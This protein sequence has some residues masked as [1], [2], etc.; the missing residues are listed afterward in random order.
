SMT[1]Q[2]PDAV[3]LG[4][5]CL[6][7][8]PG[9]PAGSTAGE[10]LFV[11]G[12]LI[13]VTDAVLSSGGATSN[14]GLALH[15]LGFD[16]RIVGKIGDDTFGRALLG[17]FQAEAEHLARDMII[18]PD[19]GTS[20]SIIL[21]PPGRDRMI[22]HS[23]GP[24]ATFASADVPDETLRG[25]LV[26]FGY[27]PLMKKIY[28]NDGAELEHLFRRAKTNGA[29]TSLDMARPDPDS[30]AGRLD[31][32]AFF[33]RVLPTVDVF[34]PSIDELVFMI[35]RALFDQLER[36]ANGGNPAA[37]LSMDEINAIADDILA[38]GPAMVGFKLGDEGFY[39]K[40]TDDRARLAAMGSLTPPDLDAWRGARL[41]SPCRC[42]EVA[43]TIGSGD[44]TIAGFL[45]GLF[46]G[47]GPEEAVA[48]AVSPGAASVEVRDANSGVPPWD[49]LK[50]RL[51]AGWRQN[52]CS[53]IPNDW[54]PGPHG[55]WR[56]K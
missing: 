2:R 53:L 46:R 20:Y 51:A 10:N 8:I 24:N 43:G 40:V 37:H 32:R 50:E 23:V 21:N 16:V 41:A 28:E 6:D 30:P 44:C 49:S 18:S 14:T 34:V 26:H 1:I 31:W 15:R 12:K 11:P 45:G 35:D 29:T 36:D 33:R 38:Y 47:T 55:V 19:E 42:V 56:K 27:P 52:P 3:V 22:M 5:I 17:I 39:L 4:L 9:F 48:M 7:I 13:E 54:E 25:R